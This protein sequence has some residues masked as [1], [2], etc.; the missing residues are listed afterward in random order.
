MIN[1]LASWIQRALGKSS[2]EQKEQ[3]PVISNGWV[4]TVKGTVQSISKTDVDKG[5]HNP[6]YMCFFTVKD[7]EIVYENCDFQLG[8][9]IQFRGKEKQIIE[10]LGREMKIGDKVNVRST[11]I[12]KKPRIL[13]MTQITLID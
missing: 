5:G 1:K 3:M 12:E 8:E 2:L 7:D 11:G 9:K 10:E 6:K 4:I 13:S